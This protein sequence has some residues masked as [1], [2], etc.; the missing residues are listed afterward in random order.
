[1]KRESEAVYKGDG[2]SVED[3][4]WRAGNQPGRISIHNLKILFLSAPGCIYRHLTQYS[5]IMVASMKNMTDCHM[6]VK[7]NWSEFFLVI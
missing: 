4:L 3:I 6:Q 2:S 7:N 5:K 1:M